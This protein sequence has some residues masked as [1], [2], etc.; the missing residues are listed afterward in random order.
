MYTIKDAS[1]HSIGHIDETQQNHIVTLLFD[2]NNGHVT[3]FFFNL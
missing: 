2:L 1:D 3:Q